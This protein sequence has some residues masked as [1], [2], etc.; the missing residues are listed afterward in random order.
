MKIYFYK[1]TILVLPKSQFSIDFKVA[2]LKKVSK[3]VGLFVSTLSLFKVAS[4][5]Y[6]LIMDDS[7]QAERKNKMNNWKTDERMSLVKIL[8]KDI[9]QICYKRSLAC[10]LSILGGTRVFIEKITIWV[11]YIFDFIVFQSQRQK[12]VLNWISRSRNKQK[13]KETKRRRPNPRT[14]KWKNYLKLRI[15]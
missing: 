10:T 6:I 11:W 4:D 1:T 14:M 7:I 2:F 13:C 5:N 9:T 8:L 3:T 15:L 12:S